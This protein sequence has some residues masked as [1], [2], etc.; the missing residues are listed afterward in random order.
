M[1]QRGIVGILG[2]V[3]ALVI[4]SSVVAFIMFTP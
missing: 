3:V 4:I 1:R 2:S